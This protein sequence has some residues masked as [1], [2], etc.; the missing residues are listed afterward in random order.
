MA[1]VVKRL[2][3]FGRVQ[4]VA[5]RAWTIDMARSFGLRGWVRNRRDGSVEAL[6]AGPE[7]AVTRML[8]A[9]RRG[10]P[11][12]RVDRVEATDASDEASG[13]VD[14]RQLPTL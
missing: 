5:Y 13:I 8:E 9:C 4:G 7:A 14:F 12:A 11:A 2:C 1:E 6:I 10:P 3:I